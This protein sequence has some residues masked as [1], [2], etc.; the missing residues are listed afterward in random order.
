VTLRRGR[1]H[2][3]SDSSW[4]EGGVSESEGGLFVVRT[5]RQRVRGQ[6]H[7][8]FGTRS[9]E[10]GASRRGGRDAQMRQGPHKQ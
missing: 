10:S 4:W 5:D 2:T 3:N 7:L 9:L 1:D 8:V 6:C